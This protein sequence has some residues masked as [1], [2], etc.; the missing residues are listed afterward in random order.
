MLIIKFCPSL[1]SN[2]RPLVLEATANNGFFVDT[3]AS[4]MRVPR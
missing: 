3:F 2:L 1:D 4:S